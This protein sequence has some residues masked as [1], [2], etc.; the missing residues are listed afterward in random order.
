MSSVPPRANVD[1]DR[2]F[3][4]YY[5]WRSDTPSGVYERDMPAAT[6]EAINWIA[7]EW[8]AATPLLQPKIYLAAMCD[9]QIAYRWVEALTRA[10]VECGYRGELVDREEA[11]PRS[12][13]RLTRMR[14]FPHL[15]V[16]IGRGQLIFDPTASQFVDS[17]PCDTGNSD[18]KVGISS[19]RYVVEGRQFVKVRPASR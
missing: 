14:I 5:P 19:D 4:F 7:A 6:V 17:G 2:F 12:G 9:C 15:W 10:G 18:T 16:V 11:R 13:Y 1:D 3:D 8:G